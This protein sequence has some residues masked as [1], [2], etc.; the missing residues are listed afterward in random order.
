M[1]THAPMPRVAPGRSAAPPS[2]RA[3]RWMI[4]A[5]AVA[6]ALA[7]L[8][9]VPLG[10]DERHTRLA[11]RV[12]ARWSFVLFWLA[13]CGGP[14]AVLFGSRFAALAR[15]GREFGLSFASAHLVHVGLVLWLYRI[16]E[17]PP[18]GKREFAFFSVGIVCTYVL[19][20]LS[21]PMLRRVLP[22]A[23]WRG[24]LSVALNYIALVFLFDFVFSPLFEARV[25][26]VFYA[27]FTVLT[28]LMPC[29]RL[30]AFTRRAIMT[31]PAPAP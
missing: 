27:P 18:L 11:L 21:L 4:C 24:I 26:P 22:F 3:V 19:A 16:A 7:L 29:L 2:D 31:R 17:N 25:Y 23:L 5:F 13:Y 14:L 15:R 9:L 10:T 12:T 28:A 6:A 1:T 20:L 8:V 30:A